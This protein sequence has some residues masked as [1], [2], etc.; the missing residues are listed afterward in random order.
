MVAREFLN[1]E[2]CA[3]EGAGV[4]AWAFSTHVLLQVKFL[5]IC[6]RAEEVSCS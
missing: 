3:H 2:R 4:H 5:V 6:T 1:S